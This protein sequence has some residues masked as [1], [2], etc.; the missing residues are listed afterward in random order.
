MLHF[1]VEG[2]MS[3]SFETTR[4]SRQPDLGQCAGCPDLEEHHGFDGMNIEP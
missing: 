3:L 4:A 2:L 1:R